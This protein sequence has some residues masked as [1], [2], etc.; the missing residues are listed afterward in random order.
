[1][2]M[3]NPIYN[4]GFIGQDWHC[5]LSANS[6]L[7]VQATASNGLKD[8]SENYYVE[9]W[10]RVNSSTPGIGIQQ[11]YNNDDQAWAIYRG[12]GG[13]VA[14]IMRTTAGWSAFINAGAWTT[15][16]W[17][18]AVTTYD[19]TNYDIY[20]DFSGS[21]HDAHTGTME[22]GSYDYLTICT[23]LNSGVPATPVASFLMDEYRVS[24]ITRTEDYRNA[25]FNMISDNSNVVVFGA[26]ET[27]TTPSG[28]CDCP[29]LNTNW[30]YNLSDSSCS[31]ISSACDLGTGNLTFIGGG[32][33]LFINSTITVN[34]ITL[35]GT[36]VWVIK[37]L[38]GN[39]WLKFT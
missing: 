21:G 33:P 39:G 1:M 6:Y 11:N 36:G 30:N 9:G 13:N 5:N 25:T 22:T 28:S 14:G 27:Q 12:S 23:E 19:G 35:P 34:K 8:F 17:E 10:G 16:T 20:R 15:N 24:N 32:Y 7:Q 37:F 18:Y 26:Q 3:G 31:A 2:L 38:T 4:K 29:G